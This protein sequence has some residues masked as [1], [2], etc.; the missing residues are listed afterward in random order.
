MCVW[1]VFVSCRIIFRGFLCECFCWSFVPNYLPAGALFYVLVAGHLP[2]S[3]FPH[4]LH[5]S[6]RFPRLSCPFLSLP[7][8]D[9]FSP[10]HPFLLFLFI[11]VF[12]SFLFCCIS[13]GCP[14]LPS[15]SVCLWLFAKCWTSS[16]VGQHVFLQLLCDSRRAILG[17][18]AVV[19]LPLC[20]H[21]LPSRAQTPSE[22]WGR[23]GKG[24]WSGQ[25]FIHSLGI[26][27]AVGGLDTQLSSSTTFISPVS[28]STKFQ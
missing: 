21:E 20:T 23:M 9:F 15:G 16:G 25:L 12:F 1:A 3:L 17:R 8:S 24:F 2:H 11:L 14:L 7:G 6:H 18:E 13:L 27:P 4:M 19:C 5:L 10:S 26:M 28:N 22:S